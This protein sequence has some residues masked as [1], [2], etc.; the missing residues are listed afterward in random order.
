MMDHLDRRSFL[1]VLGAGGA[2]AAASL[3]AA[4]N[5]VSGFPRIPYGLVL[6]GGGAKGAYEAGVID[7]LAR[8]IADGEVLRPYGGVAGTSIGCLNGWFVATGQYSQMRALWMNVANERVFRLKREF[9]KITQP[10][11]GLFDRLDQ[12]L[13]LGLGLRRNVRGLCQTKPALDWIKRY[14]DPSRPT[15]IP[16]AWAVTN[17]T[18]RMPEYFYRLPAS[19]STS[20][21]EAVLA[22]FSSTL[23]PGTAI[24]EA[25]DELLHDAL[26]ASACL[27]IVFDP[28]EL[29]T[30]DGSEMNQYCDGGVA[31]NTPLAFARTV[32]R[33]V[34]VVL[35]HP[36][37]PHEIYDNAFDVGSAAYDTVQRHIM[38]SAI[39]AAYV[40]TQIKRRFAGDP[41]GEQLLSNIADSD[42]AFLR[43]MS[44]LPVQTTTF[45]N[46]EL[47]A[48]A[49][50]MGMRDAEQGF[51]PYVPGELIV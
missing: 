31:A 5:P 41:R 3:P 7:T 25:T 4:A 37:A 18:R 23:P 2:V 47:I 1:S 27:P 16:F 12:M 42:I 36:P 10:S 9:E 34:H 26:F 35:L 40:E 6:S 46:G 50:A 24:R 30:S 49:Y 22:A 8:G 38:F 51:K 43:P 44:L 39:E 45:D 48:K 14:V 28:I 33:N 32:A 19:I 17:L 21:R 20:E 29:P 15:L 13:H 11:A